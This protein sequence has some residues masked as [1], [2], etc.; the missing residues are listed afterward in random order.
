MSYVGLHVGVEMRTFSLQRGCLAYL[1]RGFISHSTPAKLGTVLVVHA[2]EAHHAE[3]VRHELVY[4][5]LGKKDGS[6]TIQDRRYTFLSRAGNPMSVTR[7]GKA[8]HRDKPRGG[9]GL[10]R[11]KFQTENN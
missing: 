5:R 3:G 4:P 7:S 1:L 11:E 9:A 6:A 2:A 8:V 10:P